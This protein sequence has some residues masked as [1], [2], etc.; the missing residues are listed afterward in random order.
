MVEDVE[1]LASELEIET[2]GDLSVLGD[3]EVSVEEPRAGDGV[4]PEVSR[5]AAAGND[6][7][8]V[9]AR[10]CGGGASQAGPCESCVRR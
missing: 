5:M 2:F 6:G 10:T 7:V 9:A 1:H 8:I 3:G 4:A